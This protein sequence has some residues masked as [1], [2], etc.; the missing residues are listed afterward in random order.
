MHKIAKY[1]MHKIAKYQ[2]LQFLEV[3]NY[4]YRFHSISL[5]RLI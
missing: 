5:H 4:G 3:R 1:V 2:K